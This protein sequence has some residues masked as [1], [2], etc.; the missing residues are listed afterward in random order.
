MS[1]GLPLLLPK[2][3]KKRGAFFG[4]Y[5]FLAMSDGL[6]CSQ[7]N[8]SN[9]KNFLIVFWYIACLS[10]SAH[11]LAY[12]TLIIYGLSFLLNG[13]ANWPIPCQGLYFRPDVRG[14]TTWLIFWWLYCWRRL[15][16]L[17]SFNPF[18]HYPWKDQDSEALHKRK[19]LSSV[20]PKCIWLAYSTVEARFCAKNILRKLPVLKNVSW[21]LNWDSTVGA[22]LPIFW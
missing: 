12:V 6:F 13:L 18:I 3:M 1:W 17:S 15:D 4:L 9:K 16:I 21:V 10:L 19:W 11:F 22:L 2:R 5:A 20:R 8:D 7:L 14:P